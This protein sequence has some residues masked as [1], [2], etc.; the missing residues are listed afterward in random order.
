MFEKIMEAVLYFH[1]KSEEPIII[2]MNEETKN[3]LS[4]LLINQRL[5][6]EIQNFN[7]KTR[8]IFGME[9]LTTEEVEFPM[10]ITKNGK[11]HILR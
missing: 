9:I 8:R 3:E 4:S 10:M 2:L 1:E 7:I 11:T 6:V 5:V